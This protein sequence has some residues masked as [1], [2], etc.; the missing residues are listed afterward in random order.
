MLWKGLWTCR[1]GYVV[2]TITTVYVEYAVEGLRT[3]RK[4]FVM[5]TIT[6]VYVEYAVEGALDLSHRLRYDDNNYSLCIIYCGRGF[7]P[8]AQATL[9]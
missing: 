4:G 7:G 3:C 6:T 5:V 2:M 1:T 9:W 8:V